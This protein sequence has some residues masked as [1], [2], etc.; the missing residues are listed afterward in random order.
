MY[1]LK[2]YQASEDTDNWPLI[3]IIFGE[4]PKDCLDL[5]EVKYGSNSEFHWANPEEN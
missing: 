1:K 3:D 4:N 5:A 2:I